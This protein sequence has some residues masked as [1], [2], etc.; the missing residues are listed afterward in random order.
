MDSIVF[1]DEQAWSG[2]RFEWPIRV[3]IS[4]RLREKPVDAN[5]NMDCYYQFEG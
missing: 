1:A 2:R 4:A 5:D 3:F